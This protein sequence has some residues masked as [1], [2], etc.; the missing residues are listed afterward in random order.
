M[1]NTRMSSPPGNLAET[2][3]IGEAATVWRAVELTVDGLRRRTPLL[4]PVIPVIPVIPGNTD[5]GVVDGI[6]SA[7]AQC[8]LMAANYGKEMY[9][10]HRI[11]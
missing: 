7:C 11:S 1:V 5:S 10:S 8:W 4:L 2:S 9:L 3:C 6:P